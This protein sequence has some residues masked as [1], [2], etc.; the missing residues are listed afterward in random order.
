MLSSGMACVCPGAQAPEEREQIRHQLLQQRQ[1]ELGMGG[2]AAG[3][4]APQGFVMPAGM[5]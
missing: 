4:G 3:H 2:G 1:D 5:G